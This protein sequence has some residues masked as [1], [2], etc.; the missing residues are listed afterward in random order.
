MKVKM[1]SQESHKAAATVEV[2]VFNGDADGICALHQFRMVNPKTSKLVSGVKRD[3]NLLARVE[4]GTGD[5]VTVFDISLHSNRR[6]LDRLLSNGVHVQYF[7]H[8][9]AGELPASNLFEGRIDTAPD[10]CTSIIVDRLLGGRHRGWAVAAA[11]GDNL[12][13]SAMAL[14]QQARLEPAEQ[15]ALKHLGECLNYN[16]Y[17]DEVDDLHFD[18]VALYRAVSIYENPLEFVSSAP[19]MRVLSDGYATDL[20]W[21]R[22]QRPATEA[23]SCRIYVLDDTAQARRSSGILANR[24]ATEQPALAHAVL[25][26]NSRG[27]Y[28]VSVRAPV[29]DPRHAHE[30]CKRFGGGGRHAAAGINDLPDRLIGEFVHAMTTSFGGLPSRQDRS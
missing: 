12:P 6:D 23:H 9:D 15:D 13:Q 19:E 8:H 29:T 26:P 7:D 14:A 21:L 2:D 10:V 22:H 5:R 17:G 16:G 28:T 20:D 11:F 4:A 24:V 18:P 1:R 27:A 3:V 30:I 25:T